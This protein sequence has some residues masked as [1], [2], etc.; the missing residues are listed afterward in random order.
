M[1]INVLQCV[2]VADHLPVC[3]MMDFHSATIKDQTT[4]SR[5]IKAT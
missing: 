3:E 5:V 1:A 2:S 4:Q